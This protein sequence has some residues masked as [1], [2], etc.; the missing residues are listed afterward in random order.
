MALL[1]IIMNT[2]FLQPCLLWEHSGSQGSRYRQN[3]PMDDQ[4]DK[5]KAKEEYGGSLVS[6][7]N[8]TE[9]PFCRKR[10]DF[11]LHRFPDMWSLA[12]TSFKSIIF[13]FYC[14]TE[15]MISSRMLWRLNYLNTIAWLKTVTQEIWVSHTCL[16]PP[17]L[18]EENKERYLYQLWSEPQC[19]LI[20]NTHRHFSNSLPR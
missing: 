12:V 9:G 15:A 17:K 20:T 2:L 19:L 6:S 4:K 1:Y 14:K 7:F 10:L 3:I 13:F 5:T 11:N 8:C 18:G 16:P